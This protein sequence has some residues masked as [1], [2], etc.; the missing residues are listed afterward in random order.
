MS[1]VLATYNGQE[2][3]FTDDGW[4][5]ATA[6]AAKFGKS[7]GEW[8]RLPG[9]E[10]YLAA[11]RRKYGDIPYL[12]TKRGAGGGTWLHPKL[13]VRFAQWLDDDFAVWCDE[14]IDA[15]IHGK[16]DWHKLRHEAAASHKVM[17]QILQISR[18]EEGKSCAP[19]HYS[20]EVRLVSYVLTGEFKGVD[21]E[22]LG[23]RELTLLARLEEQNAVLIARGQ[24]YERRKVI[25]EQFAL[26]HRVAS[27]PSLAH[28]MT[29]KKG[30]TPKAATNGA[31][32]EPTQA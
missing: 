18:A 17:L 2:V 8:V 16:E 6:A 30:E 12:K 21:R 20:N 11:F 28:C 27:M 24:P 22:L 14:Q 3:A 26:E 23:C 29:R 9:T 15:L 25:L 32:G 19:H 7:P 31:S 10:G 13:A 5:N 4:F 1:V